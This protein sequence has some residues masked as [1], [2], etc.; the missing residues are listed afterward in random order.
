VQIRGLKFVVLAATGI[1]ILSASRWNALS[2]HSQPQSKPNA[3]VVQVKQAPSPPV[4]AEHE[5]KMLA[6]ELKKKPGHVPIL[7]RLAKIASDSGHPA[8][9]I[10]HLEEALRHEPENIE[11]RLEL[12][13]LLFERGSVQGAIEQNSTI[14]KLK[15]DNPDALYNLGAIYGNI[16]NTPRAVQYWNRLLAVDP[17]SESGRRASRMLAL[18]TKDS[19]TRH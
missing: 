5:A 4:G 10:E 1:G 16:G 2:P 7:L 15:P 3:S 8:E 18:L 17:Q 11:A 6:S 12:G 9:A 13:K 19:E 14:L